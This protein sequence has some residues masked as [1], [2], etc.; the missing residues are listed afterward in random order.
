MTTVERFLALDAWPPEWDWDTREPTDE[1]VE[2]RSAAIAA[3]WAVLTDEE[4]AFAGAPRVECAVCRRDYG[5]GISSTQ[6]PSCAGRIARG[7]DGQL[8]LTCHYESDGDGDAYAVR[9]P[10]AEADPVCD[11]C[12]RAYKESGVLELI[13][14]YLC[15]AKV[16]ERVF[17]PT[18]TIDQ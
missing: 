18:L 1:E 15:D 16:A 10:I 12:I 14:D 2:A 9:S 3:A 4:R 13:G 17:P 5:R 6:A 7:A 8:Y 11:A